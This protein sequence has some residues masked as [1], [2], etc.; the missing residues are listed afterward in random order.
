VTSKTLVEQKL[1]VVVPDV[2]TRVDFS[3]VV[4]AERLNEKKKEMIII[5][6]RLCSTTRST[7]LATSRALQRSFEQILSTGAKV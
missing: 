2:R 1:S 7:L 5:I 4:T 3:P 6:A